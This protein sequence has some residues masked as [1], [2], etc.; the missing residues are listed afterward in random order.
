M[1]LIPAIKLAK[2]EAPVVSVI[3]VL[4]NLMLGLEKESKSSAR[5]FNRVLVAFTANGSSYRR[6]FCQANVDICQYKF[7]FV[8]R[9]VR[10]LEKTG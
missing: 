7:H 10:N 6:V 9:F 2:N 4:V 5:H 8:Q 1:V 3:Q